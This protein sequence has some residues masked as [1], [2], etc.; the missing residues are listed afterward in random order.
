MLGIKTKIKA[1]IFLAT[2]AALLTGC[3][4]PGAPLPPSLNIPNAVDNLRA[5]RKGDT[6]TLS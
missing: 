6:V 1:F 2:V 4:S 3:A 5:D